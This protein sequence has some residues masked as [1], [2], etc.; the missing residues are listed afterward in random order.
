MCLTSRRLSHRVTHVRKNTHT[1]P[2]GVMICA[3]PKVYDLSGEPSYEALCLVHLA[4]L[5]NAI[6]VSAER[7][8]IVLNA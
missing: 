1:G 7:S 3:T 2:F 4:S 6:E 8:T 5:L